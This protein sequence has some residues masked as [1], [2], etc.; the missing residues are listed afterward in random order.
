MFKSRRQCF[1]GSTYCIGFRINPEHPKR[2]VSSE[3]SIIVSILF[4]CRRDDYTLN[5]VLG[6]KNSRLVVLILSTTELE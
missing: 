3:Y 4:F 1:T 6:K 2:N 5:T